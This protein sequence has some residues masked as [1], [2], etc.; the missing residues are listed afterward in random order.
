[1]TG[2]LLDLQAIGAATIAEY[3]PDEDFAAESVAVVEVPR[4]LRPRF[5]HAGYASIEFGAAS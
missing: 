4:D 2:E 5:S 1:V 3:A